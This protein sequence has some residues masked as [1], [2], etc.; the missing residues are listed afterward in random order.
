MA[1]SAIFLNLPLNMEVTQQFLNFTTEYSASFKY[2]ACL[3]FYY[4]IFAWHK[5]AG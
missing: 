2:L 4:C 5:R 1:T 3:R